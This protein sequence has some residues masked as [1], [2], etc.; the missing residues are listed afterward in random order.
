MT[1]RRSRSKAVNPRTHEAGRSRI[2]R[3]HRSVTAGSRSVESRLLSTQASA[4]AA[5]ARDRIWPASCWLVTNILIPGAFVRTLR[6]TSSPLI[7]GMLMSSKMRSG[8]S[9][10]VICSASDPLAACPQTVYSGLSERSSESPRRT[11]S[12]S[13]A[14]RIR[15][16]VGSCADMGSRPCLA[17]AAFDHRQRDANFRAVL[18]RFNIHLTFKVTDTLAHS[19]D[20]YA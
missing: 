5:R 1:R 4:P 6:A 14:I 15:N 19:R 16:G 13:S 8:L 9:D 18:V 10:S 11:R 2:Y 20:P 7:S 12:L 17:V 3:G